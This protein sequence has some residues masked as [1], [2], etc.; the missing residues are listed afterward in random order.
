MLFDKWT[1]N[2]ARD[3]ADRRL[4]EARDIF[5]HAVTPPPSIEQQRMLFARVSNNQ[6][7][8]DYV[9]RRYG[10]DALDRWQAA[11]ESEE[12]K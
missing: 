12:R 8:A 7:L 2:Q 5:R 6:Q 3:E 1:L 11:I 9:R 4:R 10:E